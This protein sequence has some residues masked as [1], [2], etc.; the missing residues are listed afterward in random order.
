MTPSATRFSA[1]FHSRAT[2]FSAGAASSMLSPRSSTIVIAAVAPSAAPAFSV[3]PQPVSSSTDAA[4]TAV[5]AMAGVLMVSFDRRAGMGVPRKGVEGEPSLR[6][7]EL[8]GA[9]PGVVSPDRAR[10]DAPAVVD[11]DIDADAVGRAQNVG[12]EHLGGR[13]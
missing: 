10:G 7:G 13:A 2:T 6:D 3:V 5:R 8:F 11:F 9:L 12:H 4:A 1:V